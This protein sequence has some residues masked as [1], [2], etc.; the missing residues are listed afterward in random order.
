MTSV[1][2]NGRLLDAADATL[3]PFDHGLMVGD[4]VF[5]TISVVRG[6]AFALRRHLERLRR[7][8]SVLGIDAPDDAALR[9][10][11][12]AVVAANDAGRIRITVTAGPGPLGSGRGA[13]EPTVL[14]IGGPKTE[15]P[16]SA[17][18]V[19]VPWPRNEHSAVAGV[20]TISYAE[21]VVA[22]KYAQERDAAE[23]LFL[24]TAGVLCEG[25]GSNVFV[26]VGGRL[27][28][29]PLSAGCLAGVTRD[30]LLELGYGEEV[31]ITAEH[32]AAADAAFLSSSTRDV[33]PIDRIDA[34]PLPQ[35]PGPLTQKAAAAFAALVAENLDP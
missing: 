31:D 1:W 17:A 19:I 18:V 28:T 9:D 24:N 32:L 29:P 27:L 16:P 35:V 7:S 26:E 10:A 11:V 6:T 8:A 2:L 5:E 13:A 25:T 33:Q 20:K 12:A 30:L 4:G 23:A 34:R 15:W 21:N 22:L 14:V 3:S